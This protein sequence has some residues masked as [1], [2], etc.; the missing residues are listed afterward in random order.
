MALQKQTGLTAMCGHTR[1]FNPS[2]QYV[3]KKIAAGDFTTRVD[4]KGISEIGMLG[5]AFNLMSDNVEEHIAK[6]ARTK[7]DKAKLAADFDRAARTT[8]EQAAA[9]ILR[10]V[11]EKKKRVLIG[12]DAQVIQLM[13]RLLPESYPA[14]IRAVDKRGR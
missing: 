4:A 12:A 7:S 1:R 3:H 6:L 2:H 9:V 5:N 13:A 8:P 11:Y 14:L 10:G